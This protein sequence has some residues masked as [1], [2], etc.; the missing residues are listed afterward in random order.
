MD[1]LTLKKLSIIGEDGSLRMVVSNEIRQLSGRMNGKDLPK[2][3]RPAGIIFFN[4][5][6]D[7][8]GGII[9][10]VSSENGATNSGMSF[11][12]DNFY[13]DQVI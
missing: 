4:N 12:M 6:G 10:N 5:Q 3:E 9:A 11:T 1:E 7:E 2:R 13:D 8:C